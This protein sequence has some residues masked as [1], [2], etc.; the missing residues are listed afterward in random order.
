MSLL[1]GYFFNSRSSQR[2]S[3]VLGTGDRTVIRETWK[4]KG[5]DNQK[6]SSKKNQVVISAMQ[7][8][9]VIMC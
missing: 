6:K 4:S 7:R 1:S 9:G 2:T 8:I 5:G 3:S